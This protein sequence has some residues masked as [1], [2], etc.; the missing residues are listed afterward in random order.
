[1]STS[2]H[3][4][5]LLAETIEYLAP[6][7]G[8][9]FVDCTLGLGGHTEAL[10][11][12]SPSARVLGIDRD[13]QALERAAG[14]LQAFGER[15]ELVEARFSEIGRVLAGR[16]VDGGIFADLGVSSMQLDRGERGFSFQQD[17]PLDMRMGRGDVTA[18]EVIN[19][20]SEEELAR[21][22]K[23]YGEERMARRVARELVRRREEEPLR[24]TSDLR[25]AVHRAKGRSR[26]GRID[27]STRVFQAL[28]LEVN[29]ELVE[30]EELLDQA[31]RLLDQDGR[32]VIISYHSLEDR[33]VKH[34]LRG[35]AQGEKDPIT[36]RPRE[37]TQLLEL[38]TRRAVGPSESEV[39]EN[40][41]ARSARLRAARRL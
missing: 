28:R 12:S 21:V 20:Y 38:L 9:L 5:V 31:I 1:M 35:W 29:R 32:L 11:E 37:E 6:G 10:L 13:P 15:V 27:S 23:Q 17:G 2:L 24:T 40:P 26:E 34:R 22:F 16:R 33:I 39:E 18:E 8:G 19:H 3:Q 25:E 30:L 7:R 41:R 36:G 14:R 4:P